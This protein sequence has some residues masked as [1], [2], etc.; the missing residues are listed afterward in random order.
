V[1]LEALAQPEQTAE[2][3]PRKATPS[4]MIAKQCTE[5]LHKDANKRPSEK[6]KTN[7]GG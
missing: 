2:Y 4:L 6:P 1:E 7:E 5:Q 3:V